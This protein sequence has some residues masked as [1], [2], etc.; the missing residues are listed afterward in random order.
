MAISQEIEATFHAITR[1]RLLV[2]LTQMAFRH[3]ERGTSSAHLDVWNVAPRCPDVQGEGVKPLRRLSLFEARSSGSG[4]SG[5]ET[6]QQRLGC[7]RCT[8]MTTTARCHR[9]G[10]FSQLPAN[11]M[12]RGS[13]C[14]RLRLVRGSR[15]HSCVDTHHEHLDGVRAWKARAGEVGRV[16]L[17][18][19][20][21]NLDADQIPLPEQAFH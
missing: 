18:V 12:H 8:T 1:S 9:R 2:H 13:T 16:C 21:R 10:R 4:E 5:N 17:K 3:L 14:S 11:A 19:L 7:I 6:A 15:L 20:E